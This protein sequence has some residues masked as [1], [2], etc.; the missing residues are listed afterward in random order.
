[1]KLRHYSVIFGL[2]VLVAGFITF[3]LAFLTAYNHPSKSATIYINKYG[4]ANIEFYILLVS[5][6]FILFTT[7][8]FLLLFAKQ[9]KEDYKNV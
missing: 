6:P 7:G 1:M 2:S 3:A 8:Y 5:I 9:I 4:E